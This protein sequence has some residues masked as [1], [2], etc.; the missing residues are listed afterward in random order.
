MAPEILELKSAEP[1]CDG[2]YECRKMTRRAIKYGADAIK[3]A[4]TGG[5]LSDTNTGTGQQMTDNELKEIV[6]TAHELGR[7]VASHAHAA[8]GINTQEAVLMY[9]AGMTTANII[10]SA[11]VNSTTDQLGTI[12]AGKFADIIA[13]NA[14]PLKNIEEL[15]NVD[16]V[17]KGGKVFKHN[18]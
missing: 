1:L 15:L 6:D 5:V 10:K 8:K 9:R 2:P 3:V 17:M 11:T 18:L 16:F 12:E 7:T 14:S 13:I 4:S